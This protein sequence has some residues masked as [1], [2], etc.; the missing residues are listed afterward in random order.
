MKALVDVGHPL[1]PNPIPVLLFLLP[2]P[3]LHRPRR[4][5]LLHLL[6]PAMAVLALVAPRMGR[7][8]GGSV[9][10]PSM[11]ACLRRRVRRFSRR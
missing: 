2:T 10:A 6:A 5:L 7:M 3:L 4:P 1:L 9:P 11:M 8:V